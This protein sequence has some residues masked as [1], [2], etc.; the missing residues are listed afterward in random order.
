MPIQ[1]LPTIWVTETFLIDLR[2]C[3]KT[4]RT[5]VPTEYLYKNSD[6]GSVFYERLSVRLP[7]GLGAA[8]AVNLAINLVEMSPRSG[9][10]P[11]RWL[12]ISPKYAAPL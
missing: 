5:L 6:I 10:Q 9:L 1:G 4:R 11:S 3:W 8:E 12:S 7:R 2:D